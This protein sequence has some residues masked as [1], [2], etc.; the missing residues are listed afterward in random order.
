AWLNA[1][2]AE[3]LLTSGATEGSNHARKGAAGNGRERGR[4]IIISRLE[5]DAVTYPIEALENEGFEITR[6]EVESDGIVD[7]ER[8]KSTI[9]DDTILVSV[10]PANNE[11]GTLQPLREIGAMC[12]ERKVLFYCDAV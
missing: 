9:R 4:H 10:M 2:P 6:L 8:L 1:R 3:I 5:H 11:L 12:R 7:P